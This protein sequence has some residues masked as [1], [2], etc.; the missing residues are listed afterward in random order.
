M[1]RKKKRE[2]ELCI[3]RKREKPT[4]WASPEPGPVVVIYWY[5]GGYIATIL[6]PI[7]NI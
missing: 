2:K 6:K 3:E 7:Q 5:I 1:Y 4:D